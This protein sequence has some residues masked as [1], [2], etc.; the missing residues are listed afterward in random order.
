[1]TDNQ[2]QS[3]SPDHFVEQGR[4]KICRVELHQGLLQRLRKQ[5]SEMQPLLCKA[6]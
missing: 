1:M 5:F 6:I 4:Q 2:A 3:A